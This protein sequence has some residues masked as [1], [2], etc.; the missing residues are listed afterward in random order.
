[1]KKY[2]AY[3]AVAL[4]AFGFASCKGGENN[5]PENELYKIEISDITTKGATITVTPADSATYYWDVI[6]AAEAAKM[7]DE[8]VGA[9]LVDYLQ[10]AVDYYKDYGYDFTIEDFL[11]TG[12]DSYEYTKLES[13]TEFTV[14]A[15]AIDANGAHG[16][17]SR[18]NFKTL[19]LTED[20][21]PADMTFQIEVDGITFTGASVSVTPSINDAYYYWNVFKTADI[22]GMND[23]ELCELI[24]ENVDYI[25]D[26]YTYYGYDVSY[27]DLLSKGPDAYE[28]ES[29]EA[30]TA[31]TIVAVAMGTLGT[32]NGAVAK[33][34]F[35]TAAVVAESELTLDFTDA[36][37]DDY[38]NYDGS[39]Q[40]I[41]APADSS[42]IVFLNPIS[43][44]FAGTFTKDDL[45][46]DYSGIYIEAEGDTYDIAATEFTG[47]QGEG[48][49]YTYTGWFI[50]YNAVKYN[51][52]FVANVENEQV[53]APAKKAL[54]K[55]EIKNFKKGN[56]KNNG[57]FVSEKAYNR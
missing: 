37:I 36:V 42:V 12:E 20:P 57:K 50:A 31:Y 26:Y 45:D 38:R 43:E 49:A 47:V 46:L 16:K 24:K 34:N 51:F 4:V 7:T 41:A 1:M 53:A 6:E 17:A 40:I 21:V 9:Y 18:K 25:I 33:Y 52:A 27:E 3:V 39:F 55:K 44:D 23:T 30:E 11:V 28:F 15:I 56:A 14:V 13:N 54:A 48:N 32:T 2:F 22:A 29:L 19:E 8:E 5:E 10:E 35:Q